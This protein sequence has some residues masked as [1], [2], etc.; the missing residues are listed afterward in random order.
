V[1][2]L[3]GALIDAWATFLATEAKPATD[4]AARTSV[5]V[6]LVA[7]VGAIWKFYEDFKLD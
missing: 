5:V 2:T 4:F 1:L 6:L 7:S 3:L